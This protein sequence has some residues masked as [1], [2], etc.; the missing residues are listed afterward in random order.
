MGEQ[1]HSLKLM[2]SPKSIAIIGASGDKTKISYKTVSN[3]KDIGY[4]GKVYLVI[5]KYEE[6]DGYRCYQD[7]QYSPCVRN[8]S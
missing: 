8:N 6:I 4:E 5:S 2:F 1:I 3:L 7:I